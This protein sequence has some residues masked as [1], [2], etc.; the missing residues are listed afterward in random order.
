MGH[1]NQP[2][3]LMAQNGRN[4]LPLTSAEGQ[5]RMGVALMLAGALEAVF[6]GWS[7]S[8][9]YSL[10]LGVLIA[11]AGFA[12]CQPAAIVLQRRRGGLSIFLANLAAVLT[13]AGGA[14]YAVGRTGAV[15][16]N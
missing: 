9:W 10:F 11:M 2:L 1:I 15:L 12:F 4:P 13:M 8:P 7:R 14:L 3:S 6:A 16:F 5:D